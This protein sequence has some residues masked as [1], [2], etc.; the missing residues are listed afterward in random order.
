M[1]NTL[2]LSSAYAPLIDFNV[3]FFLQ[4]LNTI[5]LF[6][7]LSW[8]LF[9]PVTKILNDRSS[10]IAKTYEES[11]MIKKEAESLKLEY[12]KKIREAREER[13]DLIN[14]AKDT[15][16]KKAGEIIKQ[17]EEE[18]RF[19]KL[20]AEK[21]IESDKQKAM[22]E[23]KDEIAAMAILAA[24]KILKKEVNIETNKKMIAEFINEMGDVTWDK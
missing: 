22:L 23:I 10:N 9:R 2:V 19:I 3:T 8:K 20:N 24:A 14:Q 6:S 15:A 7:F 17:A 5:I 12:E 1:F 16:Q 11:D 4:I 18:A 13:A 21:E